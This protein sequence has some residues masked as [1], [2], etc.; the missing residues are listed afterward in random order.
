MSA[1]IMKRFHNDSHTDTNR[2]RLIRDT[3]KSKKEEKKTTKTPLRD[4]IRQQ[5]REKEVYINKCNEFYSGI[6]FECLNICLFVCS[7]VRLC[8][9]HAGLPLEDEKL[10]ARQTT[11]DVT[12]LFVKINNRVDI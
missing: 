4:K 8:E 7:F 9:A 2:C 3:K 6:L 12:A 10:Y 5:Q 1:L 11:E